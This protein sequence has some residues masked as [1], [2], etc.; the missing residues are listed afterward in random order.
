MTTRWSRKTEAPTLQRSSL[1]LSV[2]PVVRHILAAALVLAACACLPAAAGAAQTVKLQAALTPER[3]GAGTTIA[4]GFTVSTTTGQVPSPLTGVELLYPANLGLA[5]SGLGLTTCTTTIL[6]TLGPEG[7]PSESQM[8]YGSGLV[9]VPFGP[10]ILHEAATTK[11]FMA[12]LDQGRLGLVF[13]AYGATPVAAQIVFPGL[14]LPASEPYGGDL[15][16]TIP[17]VP[18]LPG[19]PDA[20]VVKLSTTIGPEHLTYYERVRG[21]YLPYHPRGIVLP[22]TCPHGGFKFAAR[23]TFQDTTHTAAHT[24]VPC[25]RRH[26]RPLP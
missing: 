10:E 22:R 20:A 26:D 8:G 16:T 23:L 1:T 19:A 9:E 12:H 17:L 24:T 4:F 11:V 25:P 7:C 21:R 13:Y 2:R 14:V 5:T 6:E 18:T 15:S 3:L